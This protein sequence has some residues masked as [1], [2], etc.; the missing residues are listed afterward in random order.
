[1]AFFRDRLPSSQDLRLVFGGCAFVIHIWAI[2]NLLDE[3]PA[4]V[5]RLTAYELMGAI[6]Y[7]LVFALLESLFVWAALIVLS[8][9]LPKNWM[10][11]HFLA[12]G[13]TLMLVTALWSIF[14]HFNYESLIKNM[15][16]L[17]LWLG[18]ILVSTLVLVYLAGRYR[19]IDTVLRWILERIEVLAY[20]Y[21]FVDIVGLFIIVSRNL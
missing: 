12:R 2:I 19:R 14:I 21:I 9:L 16:D 11:N 4:W 13:I 3:L 18:A 8:M 5:M 1:M 20:M 6:S 17:P 10:R 7:P 15:R